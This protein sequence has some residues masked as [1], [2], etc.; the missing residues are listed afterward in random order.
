MVLTSCQ[1][2]FTEILDLTPSPTPPVSPEYGQTWLDSST[3]PPTI[4]IWNGSQWVAIAGVY[5]E[6]EETQ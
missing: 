6:E 2:T 4:K 3:N 1:G 5:A